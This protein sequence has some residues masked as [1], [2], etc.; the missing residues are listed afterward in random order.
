MAH[1]VIP[2]KTLHVKNPAALVQAAWLAK[3][4]DQIRMNT[5]KVLEIGNLVN[6]LFAINWNPKTPK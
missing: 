5:P 3:I 4:T 1:S 6:N 2:N